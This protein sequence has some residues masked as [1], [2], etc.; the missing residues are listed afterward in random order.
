MNYIP[1]YIGA[2]MI[3]LW[4]IAH[5]IPVNSIIKG[6]GEISAD[7]KK[8]LLMEIIADGLTLIFL[9]VLPLVMVI[10]DYHPHIAISTVLTITAAMLVI[11]AGLTYLTGAK[12]PVIWYKICVGV[13]LAVAI[14]YFLPIL[15]FINTAWT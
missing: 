7:N 2:A 11:M 8:I 13:K 14:L 12:T 3:I 1:V 15:I 9:G 4:G 10:Q 5:I 6:F